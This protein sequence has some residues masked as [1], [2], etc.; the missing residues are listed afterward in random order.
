MN[1]LGS[2]WRTLP[3]QS[4]T[5]H[6]FL[7]NGSGSFQRPGSRQITKMPQ[8]M[9]QNMFQNFPPTTQQNNSI[10]NFGNFGSF[11]N[12]SSGGGGG[13]LSP[14]GLNSSSSRMTGG[15]AFDFGS[16]NRSDQPQLL[17]YGRSNG[18][19]NPIGSFGGGGGGGGGSGSSS[20]TSNSS[21]MM[22]SNGFDSRPIVSNGFGSSVNGGNGSA[23][24]RS[25]SGAF[26][27][28]LSG[29]SSNGFNRQ[30]SMPTNLCDQGGSMSNGY[31]SSRSNGINSSEGFRYPCSKLCVTP[32]FPGF[33]N[34]SSLFISPRDK[35]SCWNMRQQAL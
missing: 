34:D 4:P 20:S 5:E 17:Q 23:F 22:G 27:P 33:Y 16:G 6:G 18:G 35:Y 9:G 11:G 19:I 2:Q 30:M 21:R 12:G 24:E 10:M 7:S 29:S 26:E 3:P 13:L 1:N 32:I 15:N 25:M 8:N 28:I 31:G 14:G